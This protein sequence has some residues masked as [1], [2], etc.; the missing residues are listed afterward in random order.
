M[1]LL[2]LASFDLLFYKLS[3]FDV[4]LIA[5]ATSF[6]SY[7]SACTHI[8]PLAHDESGVSFVLPPL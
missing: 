6:V 5:L 2:S 4:T 1:P 3:V 8:I 7:M